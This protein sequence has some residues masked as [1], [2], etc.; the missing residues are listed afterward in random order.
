MNDVFLDFKFL[1]FHSRFHPVCSAQDHL[2]VVGRT[3]NG[4]TALGHFPVVRLPL[5]RAGKAAGPAESLPLQE[6][7][8]SGQDPAGAD[9]DSPAQEPFSW[10]P[11]VPN[12][13]GS[14]PRVG[15]DVRKESSF[16]AKLRPLVLSQATGGWG[17]RGQ[18]REMRSVVLG[19]VL[20]THLDFFSWDP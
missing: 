16:N 11:P 14:L 15:G 6:A 19:E 3:P 10:R 20:S 17:R 5:R 9:Q 8:G 13:D 12:K 2:K 18:R 7:V 4:E 1:L